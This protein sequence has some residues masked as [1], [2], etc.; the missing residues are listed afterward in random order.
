MA[1][2]FSFNPDRVAHFEA[3]GWRAYYDRQ[4]IKLLRLI[5]S[6]CQE[7]FQIPFPISLLAAYDVTRAAATWVPVD[8]DPIVV[9]AYYEKFYRLARRYSGLSFDP[10]CAAELELQYND[11]HR[12][13]VGKPDKTEFI[14]CMAE[15]HSVIFGITREQAQKSAELRVAANTTVDGITSKQSTDVEGDWANLE[16]QLRQ[17]YRSIQSE[18]AKPD[19]AR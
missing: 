12:Q 10:A 3:T 7:Q 13:L 15:L 5:V 4:W 18:L 17:C 2:T 8:H 1:R 11:V 19:P 6:L 9:R 16:E 14:A